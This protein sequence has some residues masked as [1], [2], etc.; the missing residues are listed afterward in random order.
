MSPFSWKGVRG[1]LGRDLGNMEEEPGSGSH[2]LG[3]KKNDIQKKLLKSYFRRTTVENSYIFIQTGL[4]GFCEAWRKYW[5]T[6]VGLFQ[7]FHSAG[8]AGIRHYLASGHLD[9]LGEQLHMLVRH[10]LAVS[11]PE[12]QERSRCPSEI[13]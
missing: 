11:Q 8:A 2:R 5:S 10:L 3:A 9:S 4:N 12:G 6:C 1:E 13:L 7:R